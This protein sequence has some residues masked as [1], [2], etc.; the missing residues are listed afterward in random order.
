M[1]KANAY[2]HGLG[3]VHPQLGQLLVN[4][5]PAELVSGTVQGIGYRESMRQEAQQLGVNGWVRNRRDGSV[6]AVFQGPDEIIDEIGNAGPERIL[7]KPEEPMQRP[8]A[9][10]AKN[11]PSR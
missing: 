7:P 9:V 1:V 11:R 6:E 2:G 10:V 3:A 5:L 8:A 4:R